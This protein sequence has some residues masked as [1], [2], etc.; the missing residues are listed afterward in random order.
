VQRQLCERH[1]NILGAACHFQKQEGSSGL[2]NEAYDSLKDAVK[3]T[4]MSD[5]RVKGFFATLDH[6]AHYPG[7]VIVNCVATE[8]QHLSMLIKTGL[9]AK[10]RA[11]E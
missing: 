10:E 6:I 11:P 8:S 5:D 7:Q 1:Q 2:L 4:T 9:T 3:K